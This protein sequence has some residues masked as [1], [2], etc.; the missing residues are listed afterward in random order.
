MG[1]GLAIRN[2]KEKL[3]SD[4]SKM[5][6]AIG[7]SNNILL[8]L[9]EIDNIEDLK[10]ENIEV[11]E[12]ISNFIGISINEL[13]H[14]QL[15]D[16]TNENNIGISNINSECDDVGILISE[17]KEKIKQDNIKLNGFLMNDDSKQ[18]LTDSLGIA[19]K[20]AKNNL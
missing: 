10:Q 14:F 5:A 13:I 1:L 12:K 2:T 11:L 19:M 3:F 17:V 20:L 18:I 9:K 7:I 6:K 8:R 16:S 4:Y 15:E